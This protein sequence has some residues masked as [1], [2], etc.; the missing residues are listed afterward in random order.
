MIDFHSHILPNV[1][2]GSKSMEETS[3]LIKEAKEVGFKSIISTSHYIEGYY[4]VP[5]EERKEIRETISKKLKEENCD[6]D[7]YLGNENYLSDNLVQ[8]IKEN[9]VAT[10]GSSNYILFEMPMNVKPMNLYNVIYDMMQNN[11]KP[12]LAHPERYSFVQ[13]EPNLVYDLI[14]KGVLMQSNYASIV[15]YYGKRAEVIVK[16][17]L[18]NN[19]VH[20][21]GSDVH[22]QNTIYPRIPEILSKISKITGQDKL[23]ELTTI[24]PELALQDKNIS[25]EEPVEIKLSLKEKIIMKSSN[26]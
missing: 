2:D 18:E 24:N 23:K 8:L 6:V 12:I 20:F 5:N 10:V 26:R 21:L 25:V 3:N 4:E 9:K 7:I 17:L 13:D 19:M 14:E 1:D 16:K 22:K 15:G 11:L